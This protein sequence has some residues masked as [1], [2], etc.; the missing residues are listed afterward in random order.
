MTVN[1]GYI[2]ITSLNMRTVFIDPNLKSLNAD[3]HRPSS[4]VS[5]SEFWFD[6][7]LP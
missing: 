2:V 3:Y 6:Q 4:L 1:T 5:N 7:K